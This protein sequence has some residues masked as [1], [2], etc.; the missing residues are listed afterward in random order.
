MLLLPETVRVDLEGR[1]RAGYPREACGL[2]LGLEHAGLTRVRLALQARNLVLASDPERFELDPGDHVAAEREARR[3][4]LALVGVWH[5]HPD[6]PAVPSAADRA[7]AWERWS[8]LILSVG[9]G[10]LAE[11]RSWRLRGGGFREEEV[12]SVVQASGALATALD[13]QPPDARP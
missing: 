7:A 3:L 4:G 5:S 6:H 9:A 13:H 8:Y 11:L 2:L 12:R 1:V 10:G